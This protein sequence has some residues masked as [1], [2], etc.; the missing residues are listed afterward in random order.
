MNDFLE[1]YF[2]HIG[3]LFTII[4]FVISYFLPEKYHRPMAD[5]GKPAAVDA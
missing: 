5:P 4:G 3:T 2:G 1:K